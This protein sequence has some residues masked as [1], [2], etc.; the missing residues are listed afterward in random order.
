MIRQNTTQYYYNLSLMKENS[1]I[2]FYY[3]LNKKNYNPIIIPFLK[4]YYLLFHLPTLPIP[5]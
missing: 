2:L 4:Y 1:N 5:N 3:T